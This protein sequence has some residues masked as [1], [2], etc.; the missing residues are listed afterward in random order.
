M[1]D[2][3]T[4]NRLLAEWMVACDQPF[5]EVEKPEFI[6]LMEYTH[7]GSTLNF[8]VPGRTAMRTRVMQM[9]VD[10]VEGTKKMF[11]VFYFPFRAA[12]SLLINYRSSIP[13]SVSR[14][15]RGLQATST[16]SWPSLLIT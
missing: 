12:I 16:R 13:R 11:A 1:F 15:T 7:H 8:K 4:F 10:T 14:S 6:R 5:D 9:G 2:Q 3:E